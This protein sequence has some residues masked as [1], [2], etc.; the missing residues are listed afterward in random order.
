MIGDH[1]SIRQVNIFLKLN[2]D[3]LQVDLDNCAHEPVAYAIAILI[4]ITQYFNVIANIVHLNPIWS[5]FKVKLCQF[6]LPINIQ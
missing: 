5:C 3:H 6:R 1:P 2:G 4:V